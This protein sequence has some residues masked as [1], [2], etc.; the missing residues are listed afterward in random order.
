MSP[1]TPP[2][3]AGTR[4]RRGRSA[5]AAVIAGVVIAL[6]SPSLVARSPVA[7]E[8]SPRG[9]GPLVLGVPLREAA[10][11]TIPLDPAAAMIGPG[12]DERDQITVVLRVAG[13]PMS[14]MAMADAQGRIEEILATPAD[15]AGVTLADAE[16][17][18]THGENFA[19]RLAPALGVARP[20]SVRHKPV[21]T[22]FTF[23]LEGGGQ[24][25]TAPRVVSRWFSGGRTCDLLLQFGGRGAAP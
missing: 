8:V 13:M 9:I 2:R 3:S 16:A 10:R 14:V 22:E 5:H 4:R 7:A 21:S 24:G 25:R 6:A 23:A 11:Q 19:V 20:W 12:C 1:P 18:R 15:N 17:C